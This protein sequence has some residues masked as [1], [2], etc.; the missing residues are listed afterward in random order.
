MGE[1]GRH[2]QQR[3]REHKHALRIDDNLSAVAQH[4]RDNDHMIN[5]DNCLTIIKEDNLGRRRLLEAAVISTHK[6]FLQRPGY[7]N[8]HKIL[9]RNIVKNYGIDEVT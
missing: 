8:I 3:I 7:F 1:T 9:A 2:L 5:F 4:R 6:T